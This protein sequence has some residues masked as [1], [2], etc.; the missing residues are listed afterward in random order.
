M[1]VRLCCFDTH[2]AREVLMGL[3]DFKTAALLVAGVISGACFWTASAS[4]AAPLNVSTV[5]STAQPASQ[6][7]LRF[8][9][10][11]SSAGTVTVTLR[12]S[13]SGESLGQW[14]SPTVPAGAEHQ[15]QISDIENGVA[16]SFT[17]PDYYSLSVDSQFTGYFQHVLWRSADGTLTN[18]STC[19]TGIASD[20]RRLS[21]V[22]S[23]LLAA[24]Y[25]SSVV[26]NNTGSEAASATL[27]IYDARDGSS[28]GSYTS[29]SIASGGHVILTVGDI[30]TALGIT[31]ASGMFHYV[32]VIEGAFTGYVQHLVDNIQASVTT[33]MSAACSMSGSLSTA[34]KSPLRGG[35]VFSTAQQNAQSF[36]R[37]YNTGSESGTVTVALADFDSGE[38]LGTWTSPAIPAGAE[39]Q[40]SIDDIEQGTGQS[41]TPPNYYATRI[42]SDVAGY[43]QH[44]LWRP[45][46]G[47]LTNLSTC[48]AGVT[49]DR[50]KLSAVHSS[51]L[52]ENY[53][54]TI[55]VTN[56][57][58]ASASATLTIS[59]ARDGSVLGTYTTANIPAGGT[60]LLSAAD[61]ETAIG[62]PTSGMFHYV[63]ETDAQFTG[64]LQ[65]LV[66]NI[67]VGVVTDMTTACAMK[68]R[69]TAETYV[70][71]SQ[72]PRFGAACE[73]GQTTLDDELLVCGSDGTF[74]YALYDDIPDMPDGGYTERPSWYPPVAAAFR[75]N[76]EPACPVEGR[77]TFTSMIMPA[78][79]LTDTIP[80]G[81]MLLTHVTPTDHGYVGISSNDIPA[82]ERTEDD[83]V[84]V[85]A[86]AAG[87]VTELQ[88][89]S[90]TDIRMVIAQGCETYTVYIV[91][92]RLAGV[93]ADY[94]DELQPGMSLSPQVSVQAGDIVGEQRDDRLDFEVHDGSTWLSGFVSP[95]SYGREAWKPYTIDP[96]DYFTP[97]LASV[98]EGT[99][100]R[101]VEP[102]WGII[103]HD[104]A[105]T[106]VGN[107]YVSGTLGY[108]GRTIEEYSAATASV[109]SG[110][111]PGKNTYVWSHLAIA[112]HWILPDNWVFSTGWWEDEAG[113]PTQVCMD[114]SDGTPAP[115]E[116][117]PEDGTVVYDLRKLLNARDVTDGNVCDAENR[118]IVAIQVNGDGTLF[119][120]PL[121]SAESTSDFDGFSDEMRTYWR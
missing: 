121:P 66:N 18:L 7:F 62:A 112:Q 49:A 110:T 81:R 2:G 85:Y 96:K 80:Q 17:T 5:F 113:D 9:N 69:P 115:S 99:S 32:V 15:Y 79:E 102:R 116:L 30:E 52:S 84:P 119:V 55:A 83:Y 47:T 60:V 68:A 3:S 40:F 61:I 13:E 100:Q 26:V 89:L 87:V 107:W 67:Q 118:G 91:L 54:S 42:E 114:L 19:E 41:F 57:G 64:Y 71:V 73:A 24:S 27:G 104:V 20:A 97:A 16:Q 105:G 111:P 44:V 101:E 78:D 31:P 23:S 48:A 8:Y 36:L 38:E 103:D 51:L 29:A 72:F 37:F 88:M 106:A 50:T 1:V 33:D 92:N 63:I 65:H 58:S 39:Q 109:S 70:A 90:A 6:S 82:A 120:E 12:D 34:P 53:P 46:D 35:A 93:L 10:V 59:D 56:S 98:F 95:F 94:Q 86:P 25:P 14:I 117:T 45:A 77:I 4:Q 76:S 11:S 43:F 21:A 75:V 28:L 22:H 74:R 108:S